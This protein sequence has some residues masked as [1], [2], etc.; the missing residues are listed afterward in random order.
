MKIVVFG[1][2]KNVIEL[3]DMLIDNNFDVLCLIPP[4]GKKG[5]VYIKERLF[6]KKKIKVP[7]FNTENINKINFVKKIK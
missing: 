4:T 6:G 7:I 2:N 1:L 3:V 5:S